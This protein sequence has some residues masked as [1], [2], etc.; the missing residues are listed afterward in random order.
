VLRRLVLADLSAARP[1]VRQFRR[2]QLAAKDPRL[3]LAYCPAGDGVGLGLVRDLDIAD[4]EFFPRRDQESLRADCADEG[5]DRAARALRPRVPQR[6]ADRHRRLSRRLHWRLL[7]RLTSDRT[8][9]LARRPRLSFLRFAYPARLSGRA[10]QPLYLR[11][12]RPRGEPDFR[13]H[14][15]VDRSSHRFRNARGVSLVDTDR[16]ALP[17]DTA[18]QPGEAATDFLPLD[19]ETDTWRR[20]EARA[21][22]ERR[23]WLSPM[24]R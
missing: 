18:P 21:S 6:D 9:V 4:K 1:D 5:P 7:H 13:P 8:G 20:A 2:P 10:R 19:E 24:N 23:P 22:R 14:L 15:H 16:L 17:S 11:P 12:H 3:S